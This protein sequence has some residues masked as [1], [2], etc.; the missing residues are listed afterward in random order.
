M[1]LNIFKI[2]LLTCFFSAISLCGGAQNLV[3]NPSFEDT[4]MCPTGLGDFSVIGW[5]NPTLASPDYFNYC[6]IG[7]VGVPQN[8]FGYQNARTGNAYVGFHTSD[9]SSTD[10]REYVQCQLTSIFEAGKNYEVSF[11]VSK[12]DSSTKACDNI[13]VYLSST[14]INS[15]NNQNLPY[16]PQVVSPPNNPIIDVVEWIQIID[17][18]TAIGGEQFLTIGVFT[19]NT[20]TNWI[21]TSGGWESEAHYYIDDVSVK[22]IATNSINESNSAHISI[23][24][25]PS[26]GKIN[27]NSATL[28]EKLT[29]HSSLGQLV[30]S[31]YPDSA[32][33]EVDLS[34]LSKGVYYIN[35]NTRKSIIT[36]KIII[37]P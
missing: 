3:P 28:V 36:K 7:N 19:N 2:S 30:F 17:T 34:Q 35:V 24:P 26:S 31:Q 10:Y 13:G 15:S 25:N 23:F 37:N 29:I 14:A 22:Q 21:I 18:V 11:Y 20:N 8:V 16:T 27:I 12:T 5:S 33:F 6:N 4:V 1:K 32:N 9:F